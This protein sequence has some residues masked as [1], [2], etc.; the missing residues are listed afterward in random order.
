MLCAVTFAQNWKK[1]INKRKS[2]WLTITYFV[3]IPVFFPYIYTIFEICTR[4]MHKHRI[5]STVKLCI[6]LV[7]ATKSSIS[8]VVGIRDL[9]IEKINLSLRFLFPDC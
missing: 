8:H 4:D 7:I 3:P 9:M 2:D 5:I 1:L 6:H